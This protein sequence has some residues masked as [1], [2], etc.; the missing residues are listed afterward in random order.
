MNWSSDSLRYRRQVLQALSGSA[1]GMVVLSQTGL[2]EDDDADVA[3]TF[4][5]QNSPGDSI[6]ITSLETDT[7]AELLIFESEG[8]R[9]RYKTLDLEAGTE[10]TDRTIDLDEP[11][12]ET[13]LISISIQPPEGGGSYGGSRATVTIDE[14]LD[15]PEILEPTIKLIEADPDAGFHY[16]Y[17]LYIP[18]TRQEAALPIFVQPNNS[19]EPDDDHDVH[20]DHAYNAIQ[21]MDFCESLQCPGLVPAFPRY[22][23]EPVSAH[24][25]MI[26]SLHPAVFEIEEPP[27][28]RIDKQLL[29]MIDDATERLEE[30][31]YEIAD[32]IHMNG[33]S[34][35]TT[36][37]NR[38]TILHPEKVSTVTCGGNGF[39]VLPKEERDG[40]TLPYPAGV[41]DLKELVG[42][43]FN[44]NAWR[45]VNQYIY[46]GDEDQPLPETDS[47]SYRGF[48]KLDEELD[49]LMIDIFGKNRVTERFPVLKSVYEEAEASAQFTI[50]EG[51]GHETPPEIR[52]D[53]TEFHRDHLD[54]PQ[55]DVSVEWPAETVETNIEVPA[56]VEIENRFR[57]ASTATM[58]IENGSEV[59]KTKEVPVEAHSTEA[60]EI[61]VTFNEPGEYTLSVNETKAESSL[62][63]VN[64]GSDD[65]NNG[66]AEDS[67]ESVSN[68]TESADDSSTTPE[69]DTAEELPGFN[70]VQAIAAIGGISYLL[71]RR[72]FDSD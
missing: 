1:I 52:E 38:F 45:E 41:A 5:D 17:Y 62:T 47:R 22:L 29:K 34:Q 39:G 24:D 67:D 16:P 68:G 66:E 6:L 57:I 53:I 36:F 50:Y 42:K 20:L 33:F 43:E 59:A 19:P 58:S 55:F 70:V 28:E 27:L 72:L 51:V 12:P 14:S 40:E 35:S 8:D 64:G 48:S 21:R 71:K 31:G 49:E 44:L 46:V 63:V 18:E 7:E 26:Q 61:D 2:A 3:V 69:D 11:I 32:Q 9:T 23:S 65:D 37:T 25:V 56:T 13:Q 54:I 30:K 4:E 60:V 15:D 10:F